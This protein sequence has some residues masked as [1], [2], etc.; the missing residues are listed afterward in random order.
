[1]KKENHIV[2]E[3]I[4]GKNKYWNFLIYIENLTTYNWEQFNKKYDSLLSI[5]DSTMK[6]SKIIMTDLYKITISRSSCLCGSCPTEKILIED[7]DSGEFVASY[8]I[9]QDFEW[10]FSED[11][12]FSTIGE[13]LFELLEK[14]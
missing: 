4:N 2:F 8:N 5:K 3:I 10:R 11:H 14:K 12:S 7:S 9:E 13:I 6:E 1:M